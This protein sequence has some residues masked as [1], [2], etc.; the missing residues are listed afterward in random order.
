MWNAYEMNMEFVQTRKKRP[1][2]GRFF[3]LKAGT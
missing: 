2:E 3:T 1:D